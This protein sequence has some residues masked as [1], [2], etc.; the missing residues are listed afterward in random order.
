MSQKTYEDLVI[1]NTELKNENTK[2]KI[3][4]EN[5][6]MQINALNRYIFGSKRETMPKE[7][8]IVEGTQ[9][10]IFGMPENEEIKEQIE[11]KTEEITVHK[12]RI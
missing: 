1:E 11:E 4:V 12:K 8:N 2:L 3:R 7:E 5:Q 9:C 6:E 10:S